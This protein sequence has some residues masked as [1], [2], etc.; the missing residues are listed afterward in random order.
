MNINANSVLPRPGVELKREGWDSIFI[1]DLVW[2]PET[3]Q[4]GISISDLAK[5]DS[6]DLMG[7]KQ[8]LQSMPLFQ[9]GP[10]K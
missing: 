8:N 5:P 4:N 2:K 3:A 10:G 6:P 9:Y 1:S 7:L